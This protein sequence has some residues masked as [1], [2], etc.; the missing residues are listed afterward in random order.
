MVSTNEYNR[1]QHTN[2]EQPTGLYISGD[3]HILMS[4]LGMYNLRPIQP[5]RN[6]IENWLYMVGCG[7]VSNIDF[8]T[9]GQIYKHVLEHKNDGL[10]ETFVC[11]NVKTLTYLQDYICLNLWIGNLGTLFYYCTNISFDLRSIH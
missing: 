4:M 8:F 7:I 10:T 3:W 6:Q 1:E 5:I 11:H 2:S 9:L